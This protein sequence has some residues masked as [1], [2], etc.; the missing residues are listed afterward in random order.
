MDSLAGCSFCG[1]QMTLL[2][3]LIRVFLDCIQSK[4]VT[5]NLLESLK[6][7]R[8]I[9]CKWIGPSSPT[10]KCLGPG[11]TFKIDYPKL[12]IN[13]TGPITYVRT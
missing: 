10:A 5:L 7:G 13:T 4:M 2:K 1:L 6:L 11:P 3:H 9:G 12:T 8:H